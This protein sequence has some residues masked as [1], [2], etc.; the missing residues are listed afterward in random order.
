MRYS[1]QISSIIVALLFIYAINFKSVIT[2]HYFLNQAEITALFC[3]NKEK[4]QMKC[5]GKCHLAKELK[6]VDNNKEQS[7]FSQNNSS[8]NFEVSFSLVDNSTAFTPGIKNHKKS[9]WVITKD[10]TLNGYPSII[11]PPPKM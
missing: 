11:S 10:K 2:I 1:T 8:H 9:E 5:N 4:P 6:K 3:V 7:P